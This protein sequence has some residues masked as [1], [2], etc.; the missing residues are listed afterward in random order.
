MLYFPTVGLFE[1]PKAPDI[2]RLE[3]VGRMRRHTKRDDLVF[4]TI[5]LKV[6]RVVAFMPIEGQKT[7]AAG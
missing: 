5:F 7:I 3:Q 4:L 2:K 6:G 1:R